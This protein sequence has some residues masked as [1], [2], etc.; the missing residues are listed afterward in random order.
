MNG[1]SSGSWRV[2]VDGTHLGPDAKGVGLYTQNVL[3]RLLALDPR[4]HVDVVVLEGRD[5]VDLGMPDRVQWRPVPWKN[6]L[7]HGFRTLPQTLRASRP[8]AVWMPYETP[9]AAL[10]VPFSMICHDIPSALRQAQ[11]EGGGGAGSS[12]GDWRYLLKR[13]GLHPLDDWL[14]GR[15]L[16]RAAWVFSN[17][18]WVADGLADAHGLDRGRQRLAPCAPAV[19]FEALCQKV[20]RGAVGERLGLPQGY[21]LTFDTGD[22]R[23]NQLKVPPTL[24]RLMEDGL[25]VGL[26]V[27]GVRP[28]R[29]GEVEALYNDVPWR[30]KV[31]VQPFLGADQRLRLAELYAGA[32][33][34]FDPSLQEGFGMQVVEAMACG[35]PVVCSRTSA[36][37]EVAGDAA[38][39]VDPQDPS[40]MASAL[41][42]VL[43]DA[44][45][46]RDLSARGVQRSRR[47]R[48][49]QTTDVIYEGLCEMVGIDP[50]TAQGASAA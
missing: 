11:A 8:Q 45:L 9:L 4:L 1:L 24:S 22:P 13:Y 37:P 27:A 6:H 18:R 28:G 3:Q 39:L 19:D 26:V 20:E 5:Q 48:W 23:E 2:L 14:L 25:D 31:R 16:R 40:A 35:T 21:V 46:Q 29:R 49:R 10:S 32:T 17:S 12:R 33:V 42:R 34:Y 44:E 41:G 36:L 30:S 7:W 47:F 50:F 43:T 38:L 15:T